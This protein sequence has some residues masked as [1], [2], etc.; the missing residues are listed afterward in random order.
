MIR[1][2][3]PLA[4]LATGACQQNPAPEPTPPPP[5]KCVADGL[6]G[7]TGKTRSDALEKEALRLSGSTS[8]RWISPGMAVTM[9]FR[10][11]RLNFELDAQG[12]IVRA[13]CG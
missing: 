10:E 12:K 13:F 4:L 5:G 8:A 3:L 9:D 6:G 11:D 7:F 2:V 1:L